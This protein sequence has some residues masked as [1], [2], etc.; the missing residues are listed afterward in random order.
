MGRGNN[1]SAAASSQNIP[2]DLERVQAEEEMGTVNRQ[3]SVRSVMTLPAY[4]KSVRESE[5]LIA[6][7]GE[8][9]GV[10]TVLEAPETQE[11]EEDRRE[12]EM[13]SLYQIRLQRRNEIAERDDRRRRRREARDRGDTAELTR[14]RQESMLA[15]QA[16]ETSGATIMIQEHQARPREHRVSSVNYADLGIARHDG[17]RVRANSSESDRPLLDSA[18]SIGGTSIRAWSTQESLPIH[19]RGRSASSIISI[20]EDEGERDAQPPFGRSGS[21]FEV[22]SMHQTHSRTPSGILRPT[23]RS[24]ASSNLSRIETVDLGEARLPEGNPPLYDGDGYGGFEEAP[25]YTSPVRERRS[26]V[27]Q[28]NTSGAPY[29]PELGRLPSIRIAE[30]TPVDPRPPQVTFP[31]ATR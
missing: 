27:P 17:T 2:R 22:V 26:I 24:R 8:R 21:D 16:R 3:T 31:G 9:D 10:D 4:S 23:T 5:R 25:P 18:A 30:A 28:I 14:I 13:E 12:E 1:G 6:R 15:S 19:T 7:E 11:E 20:S 29:L